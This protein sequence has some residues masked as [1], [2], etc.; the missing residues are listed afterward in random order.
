LK[1]A[2]LSSPLNNKELLHEGGYL[3]RHRDEI[4]ESLTRE[5]MNSK[6]T[7]ARV[8]S[9]FINHKTRRGHYR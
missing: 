4:F 1:A 8:Y 7:I 9:T 2:R 6:T 5:T 3:A